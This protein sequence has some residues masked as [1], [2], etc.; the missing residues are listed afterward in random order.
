MRI[1]YSEFKYNKVKYKINTGNTKYG[2]I[3]IQVHNK[4]DYKYEWWLHITISIRS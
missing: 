4:N 2:N 3:T 1:Q